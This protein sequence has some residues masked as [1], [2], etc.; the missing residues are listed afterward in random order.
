MTKTQKHN[1]ITLCL[2]IGAIVFLL[3]ATMESDT[4]Q[5]EQVLPTQA[6]VQQE[7][8]DRGYSIELDGI[9]GKASRAAWDLECAKQD[10]K[11]VNKILPKAEIEFLKVR[12]YE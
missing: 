4:E 8:I 1:I 12:V 6:E 5:P 11:R 7:L 2:I 9:I 10:N 3:Y